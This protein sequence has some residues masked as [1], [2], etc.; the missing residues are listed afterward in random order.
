MFPLEGPDAWA[1][2]VT[3]T[4]IDRGGGGGE[5][6]GMSQIVRHK[7]SNGP[8]RKPGKVAFLSA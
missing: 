3:Q 6:W 2:L 1:S 7:K 8:E 4:P 5:E